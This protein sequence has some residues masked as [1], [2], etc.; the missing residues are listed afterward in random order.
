MIRLDYT[1]VHRNRNLQIS[2]APLDNQAQEPA[3][4]TSTETSIKPHGDTKAKVSQ[5]QAST[6]NCKTV[7]TGI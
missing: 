3:Y 4:L 6:P 5:K 7:N 2:T 1:E